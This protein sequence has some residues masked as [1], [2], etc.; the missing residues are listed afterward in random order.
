DVRPEPAPVRPEILDAGFT[1]C[2]ATGGIGVAGG[3]VLGKMPAGQ[4][5]D[6]GVS[7]GSRWVILAPSP[8]R[9]PERFLGVL[10]AEDLP[11]VVEGVPGGAAGDEP[12]RTPRAGKLLWRAGRGADPDLGEN[13]GPDPL[14]GG[15]VLRREGSLLESEHACVQNLG[16]SHMGHDL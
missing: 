13:A 15:G 12:G 11:G 2:G 6:G 1:H 4:G 14:D 9:P 7:A 3:G 16:F 10:L 5:P 8:V